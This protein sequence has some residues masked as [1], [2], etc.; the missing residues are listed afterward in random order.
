MRDIDARA[1]L[2]L[3][4]FE[5]LDRPTIIKKWKWRVATVHP[6]RNTSASA[7]LETQQLNEA[8]DVLLELLEDPLEKQKKSDEE[9]R[10]AQ[11]DADIRRIIEEEARFAE[12]ITRSEA[13][14]KKEAD[15]LINEAKIQA[16]KRE[17]EARKE[18][19]ALL[20]EAK[21]RA[22]EAEKREADVRKE[23]NEANLRAQE[24]EKR[25]ADASKKA[26]AAQLENVALQLERDA[27]AARIMKLQP[28]KRKRS[29]SQDI[30]RENVHHFVTNF[31][32]AADEKKRV[33][34]NQ[35]MSFFKEQGHSVTN[36][37]KFALE[38]S[39]QLKKKIPCCGRRKHPSRGYFGIEL[40]TNGWAGM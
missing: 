29:C 15:A 30:L 17:A 40:K 33:S 8:K 26:T 31:I 24:A 36:T 13:F 12:R 16:E 23:A 38:L 1:M 32:A 35:I 3:T 18:T 19:D 9:E 2:G 28:K 14:I 21:L 20:D 25:E 27:M 37:T 6:D 7:T 4:M 39:L 11:L 10:D 22:E 34:T 5:A